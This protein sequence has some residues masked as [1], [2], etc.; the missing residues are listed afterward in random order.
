MA[1][2]LRENPRPNGLTLVTADLDGV[3]VVTVSI[4]TAILRDVSDEELDTIIRQSTAIT[5]ERI[6]R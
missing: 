6:P 4:L 1:R 3:R 5:R 2:V